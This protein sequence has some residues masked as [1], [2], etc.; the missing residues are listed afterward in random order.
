MKRRV[1]LAIVNS[2]Q[3]DYPISSLQTQQYRK[4]CN[5]HELIP[6]KQ[7]CHCLLIMIAD[8]Q[9]RG[10]QFYFDEDEEHGSLKL[11]KLI[12]KENHADEIKKRMRNQLL[13]GVKENFL[14]AINTSFIFSGRYK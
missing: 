13:I 2:I 8:L 7:K 12:S 10:W 3:L 1:L 5:N 4:Y 14:P 9:D 6:N 11:N